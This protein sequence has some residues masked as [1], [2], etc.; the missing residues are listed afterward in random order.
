MQKDNAKVEKISLF[1]FLD[2]KLKFL[3][4][5]VELIQFSVELSHVELKICSI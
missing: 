4:S 1:S 3:T 2:I 5:Q